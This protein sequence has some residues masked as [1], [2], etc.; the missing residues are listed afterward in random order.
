ML[1]KEELMALQDRLIGWHIR[2]GKLMLREQVAPEWQV[3]KDSVWPFIEILDDYDHSGVSEW[4][5][6]LNFALTGEMPKHLP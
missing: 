1:T 4:I 3:Y 5:C 6:C 2:K